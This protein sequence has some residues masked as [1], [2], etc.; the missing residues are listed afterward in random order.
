MGTKEPINKPHTHPYY[1]HIRTKEWHCYPRKKRSKSR[2][3]HIQGHWGTQN[4]WLS[5]F[6]DHFKLGLRTFGGLRTKVMKSG[7]V[8]PIWGP[9]R[10][11]SFRI[12]RTV[13]LAIAVRGLDIY[14]SQCHVHFNDEGCLIRSWYC[15][16]LKASR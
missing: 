3:V 11:M 8:P 10:A 15:D 7:A 2:V 12:T 5:T 13:L 9:L 14:S 1:Q 16:H 4:S 6:G